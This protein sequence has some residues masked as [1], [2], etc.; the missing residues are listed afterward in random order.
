MLNEIKSKSDNYWF[1]SMLGIPFFLLMFSSENFASFEEEPVLK[2]VIG[3]LLGFLGLGI[4]YFFVKRLLKKSTFI[5][6]SMFL[7]IL[8]ACIVFVRLTMRYKAN[9]FPTCE[10]CGYKAID[11]KSSECNVCGSETWEEAKK[12]EDDR[13]DWLEFGQFLFFNEDMEKEG[14]YIY[15][16]EYLDGYV[17]DANWK[18][19]NPQSR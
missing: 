10:I 15:E 16:P 13:T 8:S 6:W 2:I 7:V 11:I 4:G 5:K 18:P 3:S 17:K 14:I 19:Y 9:Q 1:F 12:Y